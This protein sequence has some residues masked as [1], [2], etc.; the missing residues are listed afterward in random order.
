M[1]AIWT[2]ILILTI[3]IEIIENMEQNDDRQVKMLTGLGSKY[4]MLSFKWTLNESVL[5]CRKLCYWR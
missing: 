4:H 3:S 1:H 2:N 5:K